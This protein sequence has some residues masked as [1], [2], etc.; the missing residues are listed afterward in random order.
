[1]VIFW[2]GHGVVEQLKNIRMLKVCLVDINVLVYF[3][4]FG[5]HRD[6][7]DEESIWVVVSLLWRLVVKCRYILVTVLNEL[8]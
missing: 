8:I 6:S 5:T 7:L 4:C 1:M 2:D 3:G